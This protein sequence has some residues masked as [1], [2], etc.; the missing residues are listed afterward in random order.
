VADGTFT[1]ASLLEF[2]TTRPENTVELVGIAGQL[3]E[4]DPAYFPPPG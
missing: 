4:L 2:V 1:H 3:L